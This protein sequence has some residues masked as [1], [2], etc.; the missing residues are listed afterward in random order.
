VETA[1]RTET[2]T[3]ERRSITY[4]KRREIRRVITASE[5]ATRL[6]PWRDGVRIFVLGVG[7]DALEL[8]VPYLM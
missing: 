6:G 7:A 1:E 3:D 4:A 8:T 2:N 5:I